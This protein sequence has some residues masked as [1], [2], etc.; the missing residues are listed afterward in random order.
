MAVELFAPLRSTVRRISRPSAS[1]KTWSPDM[2]SDPVQDALLD[3]IAKKK[4]GLRPLKKGKAQEE[5][6]AAGSN[7]INIMDALRKSL[8][9]SGNGKRS[10]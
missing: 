6:G 8:A 9:A 2:V 1:S 5:T 4:K 10:S 7:V 3:I